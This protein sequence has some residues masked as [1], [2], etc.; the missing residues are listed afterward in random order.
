MKPQFSKGNVRTNCPDCKGA[1]TTFEYKH[2]NGEYGNI[3]LPMVPVE[4]NNTA[5]CHKA[6]GLTVENA[7]MLEM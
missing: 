3:I 6:R 5:R 1:V 4:N 2:A 7:P